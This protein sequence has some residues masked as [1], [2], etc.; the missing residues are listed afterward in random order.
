MD[1]LKVMELF[2]GY[3][4][5]S[6]AL[7][8]IGIEHDVVGISEIDA[9]A[10]ISYASIRGFDLTK[11]TNKSIEEIKKHLID[12]N[13][14][15]DYQKKKSN[16]NRMKNDKLIKLYN[17]DIQSNNLGDISLI[18]PH[19]LEDINL[20]TY[21]FPCTDISVA[22]KGEGLDKGSGTRSGLLWE[23][24]KIIETKKPKYLLME[25]VKNLVGKKHK[26]N[27]DKWCKYLEGLGYTNYYD[28]L[29]AKDFGVPQNRE[30]V[31]MISILG[32]HKEYKFP[33]GFKLNTKLKDIL[34]RNVDEK[35]YLSKE[36]QERFTR[37]PK[38]RLNNED[39]EVV[40]TTAPN[41]YNSK[42]DLIYDKCTSAWC[43]NPNKLISTLSARDYKQPKQIIENYITG[44]I[45]G[46]YDEDSKINQQLELKNDGVV[47]SLTTVQKDNIIVEIPQATKK[48]Y[49]ELQVP[50]LADLSYP[51]SK[52]R[53]GRV[54]D[55]GTVSPTL[56][57]TQ[58]DICYFEKSDTNNFKIRKLTP[59]ECLRLMG[60]NDVDIDKIYSTGISNTQIYKQAGNSIV[61]NV[62]EEIFKELLI[63][64]DKKEYPSCR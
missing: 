7:R 6:I 29:N 46:R 37:F 63:E 16:I 48:G 62:L 52:T 14:G 39:L 51:N 30:R 61:V 26:S 13:V 41:P 31:F 32:E 55:K 15:Y 23:C 8:N 5:Q 60:L 1:K 12:K 36:I 58:Q 50:G 28:I 4:S 38:D 34:E 25:N 57:A 3:G 33:K 2:S 20:L 59:R 22:G 27:F 18:N 9:D 64:E 40:D 54:Q 53:R 42:G 11:Q 24:E 10:I 21:S 49:I 35:Y 17:A 45:R 56:T 43:Y 19:E 44:A 47:N